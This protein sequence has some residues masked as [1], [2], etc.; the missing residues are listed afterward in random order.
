MTHEA[1]KEKY[2]NVVSIKE[3]KEGVFKCYDD[4]GI[5]LH[6]DLTVVPDFS[7]EELRVT[8][9][10]EGDIYPGTDYKVSFV[11]EDANAIMQVKA[12][13]EMGLAATNIKFSNGTVMPMK[14]TEFQE[15]A[16]WFVT[17]RNSFFI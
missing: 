17:K 7:Q 9:K 15:F 13:F 2:K 10:T 4:D 8:S 11:T 12:A 14:A 5:L 6:L 1:I 3:T 16:I